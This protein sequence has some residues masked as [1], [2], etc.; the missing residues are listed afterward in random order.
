MKL[1]VSSKYTPGQME[2]ILAD[3]MDT[4]RVQL[5]CGTHN[6]IAQEKPPTSTGCK[7]CWQAWW[8]HKIA[9]TPA[10]LREERL[11]AATVMLRHANEAYERGEF[12][13]SLFDHA[14]VS[15]IKQEK[16]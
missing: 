5:V 6:Y 10:H 9:T 13:L 11:E 3:V 8:T 12:D 4:N 1:P 14:E 7:Q 2:S 16:D 15:A